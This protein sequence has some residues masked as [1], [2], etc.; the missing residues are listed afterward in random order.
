M[1]SARAPPSQ[2]ENL[3]EKAK[4]VCW[5]ASTLP[6]QGTGGEVESLPLPPVPFLFVIRNN[7]ELNVITISVFSVLKNG[8]SFGFITRGK[9]VLLLLKMLYQII[10]PFLFLHFLYSLHFLLFQTPQKQE[11]SKRIDVGQL[12]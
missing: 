11:M 7:N 2:R 6:K 4:R 10:L 5:T 3:Q 12:R 8:Y 9:E 1:C